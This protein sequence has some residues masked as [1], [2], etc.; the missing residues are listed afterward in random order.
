MEKSIWLAG[1]DLA[2]DTLG[3]I[4]VDRLDRVWLASAC[5]VFLE[6]PAISDR[7]IHIDQP[8]SLQ[9]TA[10]YL[11]MDSDGAMWIT[12]PDGLW[13]VREGVWRHYGKPEGLLS[14]GAYVPTLAPD[15]TLW[16]RHRF[17]A[18]SR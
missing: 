17:D 16:L 2:C 13:R 1:E 9:R 15:G 5:G 8:E 3:S 6:R 12:N 7:F 11:T 4:F 14:G 10:W 18:R